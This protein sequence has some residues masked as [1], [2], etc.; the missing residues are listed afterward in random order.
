MIGIGRMWSM[1]NGYITLMIADDA[2]CR[3]TML[4]DG[5]DHGLWWP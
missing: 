3:L 4:A 1:D 5:G 2:T